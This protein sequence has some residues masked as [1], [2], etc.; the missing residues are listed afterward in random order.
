MTTGVRGDRGGV[1]NAEPMPNAYVR[2]EGQDMAVDRASGVAQRG[3]VEVGVTTQEEVST[4]EG[5]AS[6]RQGSIQGV[7]ELKSLEL[8]AAS[9]GGVEGAE[10]GRGD[11]RGVT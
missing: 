10:E 8:R 5:G 6:A 3:Q 11:T 9:M 1:G 4:G 7:P 2:E